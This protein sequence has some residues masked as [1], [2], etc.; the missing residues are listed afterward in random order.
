MKCTNCGAE[1]A[2][3]AKFCGAC[4]TAAPVAEVSD[5]P[6]VETVA[7]VAAE[8]TETPVETAPKK[9]KTD[10]L[11]KV[12]T[13]MAPIAEKCKTFVQKNKMWITCGACL[14]I[15]LVTVLLIVSACNTGNGFAPYERAIT[16]MVDD[17]TVMIQFDNKKVTKTKIEAESI[18]GRQYSLDGNVL[19]FLTSDDSLVVVKG[20]KATVVAEDVTEFLLSVTG[21]GIAFVT[22]NDD[23]EAC[24]KLLKVGKKKAKTAMEGY[25]SDFELSP[26][27]KSM[28]YLKHDE[29]EGKSELFYFTGSKSKKITSSEVKLVGLSNKGK[30]IYVVGKNDDGEN[31]LYSY[32]TRGNKKKVGNCS[33]AAF[34]F[35]ED[36]T[37]ILFFDGTLSWSEGMEAKTYISKKGK[38][39]VKISS[40][41]AVPLYPN[42]SEV[43]D[44]DHAATFPAEDLYNKVYS[45]YKDG[46]T[47][48][49]LIKKNVD[50]SKKL[51][52]NV[53][54]AVLDESAKYVYYG[55]KDRD[56]KVLKISHGDRAGDK[57]KLIAEDV[58]NFV[59]TSNRS[60]VYFI[61][62][63]ALYSVNGKTGK[64]KKTIASENV[65]YTLVL[66]Q[67]DICYYYVDSD[68][69]ACSNGRRGKVVVADAEDLSASPN[70]I[71]YVET[72]D[73]TYATKT[74]KKLKKIFT[75]G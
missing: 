11:A 26:D 41:Y 59:V 31:V 65:G 67:K 57:A 42:S 55:D 54:G 60:K 7:E 53:S 29:E 73:A 70:G 27:G 19:A 32:N 49:W 25:P 66:N 63:D 9:E 24:L 46:Q 4:G 48:L 10:A 56:L 28:I 18:R 39:A 40:S 71:V 52:S 47:N 17:G 36:H 35:N 21:E 68:V 44:N 38:E 22:E 13:A 3:G 33:T 8:A 20:K 15:L 69:Y 62:D 58:E 72:E 12:K 30:Q 51:V 61:S 16:A 2:E 23:G 50:N 5:I 75:A 34:A 6:E 64:G 14:A 43:F 1:I 74:A 45:C 37:Q